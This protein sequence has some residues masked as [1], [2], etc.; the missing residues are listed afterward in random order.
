MGIEEQIKEIEDEI[1]NTK[2]NKATQHHIGRLKAKLA[3][4]KEQSEKKSGGKGRSFAI[5]KSGNA[6]IGLIGFPSVGKS[7]LLNKIT[8]AHSQIGDYDFTTIDIV[9]GLMKYKGAKIQVL[10]LPGLIKDASKGRGRGREIIS[11]ARTVDLIIMLIDVFQ[12]GQLNV[13]LRELNDAGIRLNS[14]PPDIVLRR[15]ERGGISVNSTVNLTKID[16]E[17]IKNILNEYGYINADI[18]LRENINEDRLIDFLSKNRAY[19]PGFVVLNKIDL[20]DEKIVKN[21]SEKLKAWELIPISADKNI[22]LDLLKEKIF[23]KLNFIRIYMR[24]DGKTDYNEPMVVKKYSTVGMICD[25]IHRDFRK[26]FRYAYIWGKSALYPGQMVGLNH[27][28]KDEDVLTLVFER[29]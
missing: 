12:L 25:S 22:N 1:K 27:I 10:D 5:K 18:V 11:V 4:L 20:G 15:K 23:K 9:P 17:M 21:C 7:T 8:D 29:K 3:R 14:K 28:L 13:L 2:Y 19:I 24:H 6:T 26:K 16:E